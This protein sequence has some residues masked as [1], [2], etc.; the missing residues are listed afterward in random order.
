VRTLKSI[1]VIVAAVATAGLTSAADNK[2][3]QGTVIGFNGKP[4]EGAEVRALRVDGKVTLISATTDD[5][6][7]Y[8]FRGLPVGAYSLTAC[9]DGFPLS[10]ANVKTQSQGWLKV[11][12]DLRLD[13]GDSMDRMQRDLRGFVTIP[14]TNPH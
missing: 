11:D 4:C 10:R 7:V 1:Y 3:I 12:F 13:A 2:C 8:V 9:V 5:R 14:N 6:G